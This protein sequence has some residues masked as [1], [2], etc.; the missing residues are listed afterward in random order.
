VRPNVKARSHAARSVM[1]AW[2]PEGDAPLHNE[3]NEGA[4]PLR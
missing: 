1:K 2:T 3:K 4:R